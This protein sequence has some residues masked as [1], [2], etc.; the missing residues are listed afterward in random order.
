MNKIKNNLNNDFWDWLDS[1][2]IKYKNYE[3]KNA[4][5]AYKYGQLFSLMY[6]TNV[7]HFNLRKILSS[8]KWKLILC[9]VKN[10]ML[11]KDKKKLTKK[12]FN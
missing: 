5:I 9:S 7:T 6:S 12:N 11:K 8:V 4:I 10:E 1:I 2:S 3:I